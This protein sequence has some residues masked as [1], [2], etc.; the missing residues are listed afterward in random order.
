M[1]IYIGFDLIPA[2]N[3]SV[4]HTDSEVK[5][6]VNVE[7]DSN[8]EIISCLSSWPNSCGHVAHPG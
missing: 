1:H 2:N 3:L 6:S 7:G 4:L 8:V 5:F